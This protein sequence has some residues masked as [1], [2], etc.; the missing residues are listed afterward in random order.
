M[1]ISDFY[2]D[3]SNREKLERLLELNFEI[4]KISNEYSFKQKFE[5]AG[6]MNYIKSMVIEDCRSLTE[7]NFDEDW[8]DIGDI[9][10]ITYEERS[11]S[12]PEG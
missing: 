8:V 1:R 12:Q 6:F 4:D 9:G 10:P 2:H 3:L 11:D 7:E 5:M